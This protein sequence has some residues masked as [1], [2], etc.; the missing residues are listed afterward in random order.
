MNTQIFNQRLLVGVA[1]NRRTGKKFQPEM[2]VR[3]LVHLAAAGSFLK[4]GS[5]DSPK[6]GRSP[7]AGFLIAGCTF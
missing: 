1:E 7:A 4:T 6:T 3:K 2:N 5:A